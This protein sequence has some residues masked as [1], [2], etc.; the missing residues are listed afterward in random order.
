MEVQLEDLK[1]FF[2]DSD[3]SDDETSSSEILPDDRTAGLFMLSEGI[4]KSKRDLLD[5][6]PPWQVLDRLIVRYFTWHP[7]SSRE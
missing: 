3:S 5:L 2:D 4:S 7:P 1:Q 6:L